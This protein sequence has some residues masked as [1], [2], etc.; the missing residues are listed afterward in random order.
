[1]AGS[2][3]HNQQVREIRRYLKGENTK[4]SSVHHFVKTTPP[5][6]GSRLITRQSSD[7]FQQ[8]CSYE[9]EDFKFLHVG[10]YDYEGVGVSCYHTHLSV[11]ENILSHTYLR[12]HEF[13]V[14]DMVAGND[15]FSN[16]LFTQFDILCLIVEPT[17]ESVTMVNAYRELLKQ[18]E[19]TTKIVLLA[20][21]IEDAS[22]IEYLE[23]NTLVPDFVFEY[24]KIIKQARQKN[25]IYISESQNSTWQLLL[26]ACNKISVSPMQKLQE[27]HSLHKK[28]IELDYIKMPLGDISHQI[29][30]TFMF[31]G[32]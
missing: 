23:A 5:G 17:L 31:P 10:T 2:L 29:D 9:E 3:S 26:D 18:T 15:V 14:T 27:L 11:F 12:N 19:S 24:E 1:E 16:T 32:K 4:I 13:L 28:Y 20:N 25:E 21:K 6:M 22:D 7:F 30:T 8:F